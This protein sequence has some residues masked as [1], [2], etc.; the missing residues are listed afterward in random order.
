MLEKNNCKDRQL[1]QTLFNREK[2]QNQAI[3]DFRK[4]V[5]VAFSAY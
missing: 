4:T 3:Q 1:T 2:L 5:F